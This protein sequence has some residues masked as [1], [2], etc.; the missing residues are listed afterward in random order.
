MKA[1][2]VYCGVFAAL[3]GCALGAYAPDEVTSLPGWDGP[4][5]TKHYSGYLNISKTRHMHYWFVEAEEVHDTGFILTHRSSP[6]PQ[7]RPCSGSMV[8]SLPAHFVTNE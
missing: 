1:S 6:Q 7:R 2:I 3:L 8:C 5:P 4:L